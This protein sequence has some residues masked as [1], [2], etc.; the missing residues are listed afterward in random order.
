M[1]AD[2]LFSHDLIHFQNYKQLINNLSYF[3]DTFLNVD[4]KNLEEY[5][6]INE[7]EEYKVT[8]EKIE[9]FFYSFRF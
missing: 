4:K 7:K 5:K 9:C 6:V 1:K 8:N 2:L 3:K